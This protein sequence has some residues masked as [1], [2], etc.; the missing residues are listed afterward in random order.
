MTSV[1]I[2]GTYNNGSAQAALTVN[3]G[4]LIPQAGWLVSADSQETTCYNGAAANAIDGNSS[5]HLAHPVLRQQ[6][7][8]TAP[9]HD[10]SW[11]PSTI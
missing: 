9:D 4:S 3:P 10:Q 1:N 5:H 11:E 8:A 2:T 7:A 6:C